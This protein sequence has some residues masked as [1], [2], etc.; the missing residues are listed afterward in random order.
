[1]LVILWMALG[2]WL[3]VKRDTRCLVIAVNVACRIVIKAKRTRC[4]P[5][6]PSCGLCAFV[7]VREREC[8]CTSSCKYSLSIS[9]DLLIVKRKNKVSQFN[10]RNNT[11]M[12]QQN[13]MELVVLILVFL[14]AALHALFGCD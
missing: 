5:S 4:S 10:S 13:R 6:N 3:A 11:L 8:L 7:C 2:V 9:D 1:M 14:R 12:V